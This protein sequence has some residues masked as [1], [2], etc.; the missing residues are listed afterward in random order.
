MNS[1]KVQVPG[2][3]ALP[4]SEK[5]GLGKYQLFCSAERFMYKVSVLENLCHV[6]K[7]PRESTCMF[8]FTYPLSD[9]S[10]VQCSAALCLLKYPFPVPF[11][12]VANGNGALT[13][14]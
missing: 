10:A 5:F 3:V 1:K 4:K 2:C 11:P 12:T 6:Q 8:Y 14:V 9:C 13:G 7:T